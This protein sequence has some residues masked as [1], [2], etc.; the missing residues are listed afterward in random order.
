MSHT[1]V[2]AT[3]LILLGCLGAYVVNE[4]RKEY[5]SCVEEN[6][7]LR[8]FIRDHDFYEKQEQ[9]KPADAKQTSPETE[10]QPAFEKIDEYIDE[11]GRTVGVYKDLTSGFTVKKIERS[12]AKE[13]NA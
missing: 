1:I 12:S 13:N 9:S 3:G 7:N 6:N 8:D 11:Q 5:D 10:Y 4:V 2:K